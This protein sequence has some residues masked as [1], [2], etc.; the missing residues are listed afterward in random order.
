MECRTLEGKPIQISREKGYWASTPPR[1]ENVREAVY[2]NN[3]RSRGCSLNSPS[4]SES[5]IFR[6]A[7]QYRHR[8]QAV[9]SYPNRNWK[10]SID[11][12]RIIS[13]GVCGLSEF[14]QLSCWV[15]NLRCHVY[16][17]ISR[18]TNM[19]WMLYGY[20]ITQK[21]ETLLLTPMTRGRFFLSSTG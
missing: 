11:N 15:T 12:F 1:W 17:V 6:E 16:I 5:H 4:H 18:G 10:Q 8:T 7:F 13:C 19:C 21:L 20:R 2:R 3:Q 14:G 9:K